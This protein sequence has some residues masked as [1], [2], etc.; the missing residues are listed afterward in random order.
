MSTRDRLDVE[1]AK[2]PDQ[3][4][5]KLSRDTCAREVSLEKLP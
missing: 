2:E 4:R 1:N 3:S 5:P